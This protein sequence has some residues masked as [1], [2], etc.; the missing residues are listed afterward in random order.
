MPALL[1]LMVFQVLP[2]RMDTTILRHPSCPTCIVVTQQVRRV[3]LSDMPLS[4]GF[5]QVLRRAD[6]T[7]LLIDNGFTLPPTLVDTNGR[8]STLSREGEGPGEWRSPAF[9]FPVGSDSFALFDRRLLRMTIYSWSGRPGK[10]WNVPMS[11]SGVRLS[12]DTVLLQ[13]ESALRQYIGRTYFVYSPRGFLRSW[14]ETDMRVVPA[15][16]NRRTRAIAR[17]GNY[18]WSASAA[19]S[20]TFE[21]RDLSGRLIQTVRV[22]V[23]WFSTRPVGVRPDPRRK[24]KPITR[25]VGIAAS[26][27]LILALYETPSPDYERGM[28]YSHSEGQ[29]LWDI[30]D[31]NLAL[32]SWLVVLSATSGAWIAEQRFDQLWDGMTNEGLLMRMKDEEESGW[33]EFHRVQLSDHPTRRQ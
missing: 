23:P 24:Y 19:F 2:A 21:Q 9:A 33:M 31:K 15:E 18:V 4:G 3:E 5:E 14:S 10:S 20:P 32:D 7:L 29:E 8:V 17:A 25:L 1:A 12:G 30:T 11:H 28:G 27:S 6:G 13:S 26:D 22:D 16:G